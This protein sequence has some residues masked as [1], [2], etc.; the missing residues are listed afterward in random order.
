MADAKIT[1]LTE[2]TQPGSTDLLVIVDQSGTPTTKKIQI[3]NALRTFIVE[4]KKNS[5]GTITSGQAVYIA[6][7]DSVD[8]VITVELA[9]NTLASTMP[10]YGIASNSITDTAAGQV[11]IYGVLDNQNTSAYSV[12]DALYIGTSGALTDTKPT[13]STNLIQKI[14]TV[15]KADAGA[16]VIQV[17]GAGRSNDL[18]NLTQNK[19]WVGNASGVPTEQ[20]YNYKAH[21]SY[22]NSSAQTVAAATYVNITLD[23][24]R[25]SY[26]NAKFTKVSGTDFRADYTGQV[27]VFY[28]VRFYAANNARDL[29]VIIERQ[30]TNLA[31]TAREQVANDADGEGATV[32]GSFILNCT[33]NDIFRLKMQIP[34]ANSTMTVPIDGAYFSVGF[35]RE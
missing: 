24:D 11:V 4:A 28:S 9:D 1:A 18:P 26:A 17:F 19:V 20:P 13:G 35:Y 25:E 5:A 22:S 7:Y 34:T 30:G 21:L 3:K 27:Q 15:A 12:G 31:W 2:L 14:G 23:T 16:G 8:G 6:G 29:R 32:S 33:T 10:A